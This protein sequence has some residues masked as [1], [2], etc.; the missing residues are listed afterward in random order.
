LASTGEK[1]FERY[2]LLERIGQGGMGEVYKAFDE[3]LRCDVALKFLPES[4]RYEEKARARLL[5][6]ARA[7]ARISHPSIC[8]IRDFMDHDGTD[9]LVM[10]FV[11][12]TTLSRRVSDG[13]FPEREALRLGIELAEGL[14]AAHDAGVLHLDLKPANIALLSDGRL[15]ILDFG[16]AKLT[17]GDDL[18]K[19]ISTTDSVT[20][21]GTLP[22]I[23]PE[24]LKG[25]KPDVKSDLYSAGCV[26]YEMCTG[27]RAYPEGDGIKLWHAILNVEPV[28]PRQIQP[29]LSA[30]LERIVLDCMAKEPGRRYAT[31][32]E[33]ADALRSVGTRGPS[34]MRRLWPW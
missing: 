13:P 15:K 24:I 8:N 25:A 1:I 28:P 4:S 30:R 20:V 29:I 21:K 18:S 27:R 34:L 10:E 33:L 26:L 6:E 5:R 31:T 23:A 9:I 32:R 11:D 12:G 14:G 3:R 16:L 22:Y 7:L 2:V 19:S 17:T